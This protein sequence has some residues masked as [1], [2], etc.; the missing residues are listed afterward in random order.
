MNRIKKYLF[1][2][3]AVSVLITPG[4][5]V[6]HACTLWAAAGKKVEGEGVILAKNR[7]YP[8][9]QNELRFVI[10]ET[11]FKYFGIFP[12]EGNK[13]HGLVAGI[14]EK[15]LAIVSATAGSVSRK[16]RNTG[17]EGLNGKILATYGSVNSLLAN[18]MIFT[19]SHPVFYLIAD[20]G[21]IAIIE[22]APG[23]EISIRTTEN[24]VLFHTNHYLDR[25]LFHSNEKI[26]KSSLARFKRIG[27]LLSDHA[28][29]LTIDDFVAFSE[30][31]AGGPDDSIWRTGGAPGKER[32]LATW[33]V[34]IPKNG[35][36][37]LY[38][39]FANPDEP[40]RSYNMK[41]DVPFW[42]EGIELP[43]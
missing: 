13:F 33:I 23:G 6:S 4:R 15:G 1:I 37:E 39:K 3:I 31:T 21:E 35:D 16:R 29:Y 24:G 27:S 12:I 38:V 41:L 43:D 17:M 7:D 5:P 22:V 9:Q 42:T 19:K 8:P 36:P 14:N 18:K 30:D 25:M 32:T 34:Y 40:T 2:L 28:S 11:G 20:K 26:G 10:P